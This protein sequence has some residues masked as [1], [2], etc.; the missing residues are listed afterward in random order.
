MKT[1][2]KLALITCLV[3]GTL[4]AKAQYREMG[5][6]S[7]SLMGVMYGPVFDLRPTLKWG[8]DFNKVYRFRLDRTYLNASS[9]QDQ[10]Y[11][12]F[13]T[14]F[15][16]GREKRRPVN[17]KFFIITAPEIGTYYATSTNYQN[18]SPSLRYNFGALYRVN[19]HIVVSVEAP[20]S[21]GLNF[22][23]SQGDW[24]NASMN[25]SLLGES[26]LLTLAYTFNKNK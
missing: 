5:L 13:S 16:F 15:F 7:T 11:L 18:I 22:Y 4:S 12:N 23:Q 2:T 1:L 8:K 19:E 24:Q 25:M 6:Q 3:F 21:L 20:L 26:P 17:D 14:G 10:F 9:Y